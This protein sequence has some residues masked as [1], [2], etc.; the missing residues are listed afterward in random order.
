MF[1]RGAG[2]QFTCTKKSMIKSA[3]FSTVS[4]RQGDVFMTV[5]CKS[6]FFPKFVTMHWHYSVCGHKSSDERADTD[7]LWFPVSFA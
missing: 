4:F 6:S 1:G 5:W 7:L 2:K 3:N